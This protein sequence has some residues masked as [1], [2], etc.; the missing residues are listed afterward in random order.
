MR[1]VLSL[2][3]VEPLEGDLGAFDEWYD[4]VCVRR[5]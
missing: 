5:A 2:E 4:V 1:L 3:G